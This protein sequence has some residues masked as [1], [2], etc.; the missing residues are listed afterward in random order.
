MQLTSKLSEGVPAAIEDGEKI[1]RAVHLRCGS[2]GIKLNISHLK[3]RI[4]V[5]LNGITPEGN[6]SW[7]EEVLT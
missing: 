5:V 2:L 6:L 4:F 1:G 3:C 7:T